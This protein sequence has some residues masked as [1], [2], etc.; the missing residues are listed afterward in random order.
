MNEYTYVVSV[1]PIHERVTGIARKHINDNQ[2]FG[3]MFSTEKGP[4]QCAF[5]SD[6]GDIGV[7][8]AHH[9]D[10]LCYTRGHC[11]TSA[12]SASF[13]WT[14]SPFS[15]YFEMKKAPKNKEEEEEDARKTLSDSSSLLIVGWLL[16]VFEY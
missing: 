15:R 2:K 10:C 3:K 14:R 5:L 1:Y 9:P 12:S 13:F 7:Q 8:S 16:L 4:T 6:R 11:V